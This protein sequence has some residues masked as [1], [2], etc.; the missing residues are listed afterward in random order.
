MVGEVNLLHLPPAFA[1]GATRPL[2]RFLELAKG[3]VLLG[4]PLDSLP[5]HS[6]SGFPRIRPAHAARSLHVEAECPCVDAG[7]PRRMTFGDKP[8]SEEL[9]D[10]GRAILVLET[11]CTNREVVRVADAAAFQPLAELAA[12]YHCRGRRAG[13]PMGCRRH[14]DTQS[15]DPRTQGPNMA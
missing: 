11:P 8:L 9:G 14:H 5:C 13:A 15:P 10:P 2:R 3:A 12:T 1:D 4:K 6:Q 7:C